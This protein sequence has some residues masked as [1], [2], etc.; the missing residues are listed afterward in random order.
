MILLVQPEYWFG[1]ERKYWDE[2][3]GWLWSTRYVR[4]QSKNITKGF[5]PPVLD[6]QD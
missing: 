6:N 1:L 3:E 2:E 5:Y 4:G